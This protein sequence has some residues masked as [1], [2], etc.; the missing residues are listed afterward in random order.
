MK[1]LFLIGLLLFSGVGTGTIEESGLGLNL[2]DEGCPCHTG[3]QL[4]GKTKDW[5]TNDIFQTLE[6]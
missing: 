1:R 2:R 6:I 5:K 4:T 3:Y